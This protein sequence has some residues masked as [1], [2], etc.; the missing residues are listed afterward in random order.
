MKQNREPESILE[1]LSWARPEL[2]RPSTKAV[3]EGRDR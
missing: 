3:A 1:L 2:Q